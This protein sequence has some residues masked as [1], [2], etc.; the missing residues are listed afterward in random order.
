MKPAVIAP[1]L[2][3]ILLVAGCGDAPV[4][5][6]APPGSSARVASLAPSITEI[7]CALGAAGQLVGR[8]TACDYPPDTIARLPIVGEFGVPSMERLLST[9]PDLVL[10]T[11]LA[12]ET[13]SAR[14]TG[15]GLRPVR[16]QCTRLADVPGAIRTIGSLLSRDAIAARLAETMESRIENFR[17]AIPPPEKR[18]RVLILIWNDP[19]T[20]AGNR[21]FLTELITLAGGRNVADTIQ[22]DYFQVSGEWVLS[23][24]PDVIF[25]FFMSSAIPARDMIMS[26][27]GWGSVNA[28]R[29]GRVYAGMD[30]NL[31][32]RPGPRMIEGIEAIQQ[33][34]QEHHAKP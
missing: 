9:R 32:L 10:F 17:R 5:P 33:R 34:L 27:P 21:S 24:N 16:V 25:C 29:S 23:Q 31:V 18:P 19:L 15:A 12:D 30:N 11:D 3:S 20:A 22:R 28:V 7:V 1:I 8:S 6:A 2:V 26:Q 13:V 4:R 14:L